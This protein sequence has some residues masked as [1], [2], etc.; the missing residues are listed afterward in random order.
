M[1]NSV[2]NSNTKLAAVYYNGGT[3]RLSDL[4]NKFRKVCSGLA[5]T[6]RSGHSWTHHMLTLI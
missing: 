6:K 5:T 4:L 1:E 2:F 3:L